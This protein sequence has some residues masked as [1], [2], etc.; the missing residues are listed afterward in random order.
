MLMPGGFVFLRFVDPLLEQ[1]QGEVRWFDL[2]QACTPPKITLLK[3]QQESSVAME[4]AGLFVLE[5]WR[6][7]YGRK[8]W[9]ALDQG[10]A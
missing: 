3:C 1:Q 7:G 2:R 4:A 6:T 9:N 8:P 10:K 5:S